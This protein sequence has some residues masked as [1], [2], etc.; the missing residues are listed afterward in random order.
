VIARL[1]RPSATAESLA[2]VDLDDLQA[3]GIDSI[4]L[5]LDNTVVAWRRF[6]VPESVTRWIADARARGMKLCIVSNTWNS[7]RLDEIAGG[8]GIPSLSRAAKP[9]RKGFRAAMELMGSE[10]RS[11]AAIGDQ[12][13]T[14]ILG[15]NRAGLYTILVNPIPS[16]EFIGTKINRLLEKLILWSLRRK[17]MMGTKPD[18]AQS[19]REER[20]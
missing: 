16:R 8:L 19:E 11:A 4:I 6:D 12:T 15:G 7:K 10:P 20:A 3:R 1:F 18:Q 17:G 5:D 2:A 9:R 14:D 13:V